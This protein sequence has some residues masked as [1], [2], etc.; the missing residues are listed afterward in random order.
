MRIVC[1]T[2]VL[3]SALIWGGMPGRVLDRVEA[4]EDKLF[5]SPPL[6]SELGEVLAYPRIARVLE[7]RGLSC[8][9]ILEA[10]ASIADIVAAPTHPLRVVPDDPDDDHVLAC[11]KAAQA[12][13]IV[14]GDHHLLQLGEWEHVKILTPSSF[15]E[16]F[17]D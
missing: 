16:M 4:G 15:L 13:A 1:D 12:N 6:L 3:V 7:R 10:V 8:H 2:N 11:A 9:D 5:M 14:T 17:N